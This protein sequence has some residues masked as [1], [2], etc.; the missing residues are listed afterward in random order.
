MTYAPNPYNSF[1]NQSTG[2]A[3][4]RATSEAI[5]RFFNSVYA[6]M[7]AGLA[8]T[9][10]VAW[11]VAGHPQIIHRIGGGGFLAL[12]L[13]EL[14]LV[15]TVSAAV[16][17]IN[18]GVATL[19]FLLYA[20]INGIVFSV[21]VLAFPKAVLASAFAISAGMFGAMS[22]YGFFTRRDLSGLRG[23]LFMALIG[24]IIASVVN[25]FW[26]SGALNMLI[27]YAGVA[28]FVGLTAYDTQRLKQLAIV[29][30]GDAA[31]AARLSISGALALYLDFINLFLFLVQILNDRK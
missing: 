16:R 24:L 11:F 25:I 18:A 21:I 29:T 22:L 15:G 5:G 30:R 23:L 9:A 14:V 3:G 17:K 13:V 7:C 19:L 4:D 31:F 10:L 28:I 8:L 2:A 27:N 26:V 1:A 6:W 20:G 12:F